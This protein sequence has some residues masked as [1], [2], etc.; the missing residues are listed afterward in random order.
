MSGPTLSVG[1]VVVDDERLLLVRRTAPPGA[2]TW[3][4]PGGR[5]QV[6]ETLAEAVTRELRE[7]T[8]LEGVCGPLIGWIELVPQAPDEVHHVILDFEVT[9]FAGAEPVAGSDAGSARWVALADVAEERLAPGL[10]EFLHDHGI[11]A[12]IV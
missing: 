2:G 3:A 5:V 10:A 4:V 11:I 9:L 12:T 1:A 7:E 8:G 6:G